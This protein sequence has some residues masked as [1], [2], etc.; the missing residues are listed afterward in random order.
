MAC[1]SLVLVGVGGGSEVPMTFVIVNI[2]TISSVPEQHCA[3]TELDIF[4]SFNDRPLKENKNSSNQNSNGA[5]NTKLLNLVK[6]VRTNICFI[7]KF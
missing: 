2:I 7:C 6:Y 1:H 4:S 5:I 3:E